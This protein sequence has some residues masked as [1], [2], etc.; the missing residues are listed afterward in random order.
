MKAETLKSKRTILRSRNAWDTLL[1]LCVAAQHKLFWCQETLGP[2]SLHSETRWRGRPRNRSPNFSFVLCIFLRW[3]SAR[4]CLLQYIYSFCNMT[5]TCLHLRRC[6]RHTTLGAPVLRTRGS[7]NRET[8]QDIRVLWRPNAKL[9]GKHPKKTQI[10]TSS[11]YKP[12]FVSFS[13]HSPHIRILKKSKQMDGGFYSF[14]AFPVMKRMR[15]SKE[16]TSPP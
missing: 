10:W 2:Y 11:H 15:Q 16:P 12:A 8:A 5:S 3:I 14:I 1:R 6:I 4:T 9:P 13:F 7:E